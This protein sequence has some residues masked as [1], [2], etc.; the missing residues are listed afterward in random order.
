MLPKIFDLAGK[1]VYV[2]FAGYR[3]MVG[4]AIVRRLADVPGEII[5]VG[6]AE[7]DLERQEQAERFLATTSRMW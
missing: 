5:T 4:S 7:V 1:R 2:Y 6:R 3:G